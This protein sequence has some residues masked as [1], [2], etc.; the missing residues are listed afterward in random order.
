[1]QF[2]T[3]MILSDTSDLMRQHSWTISKK[4]ICG[5]EL[6]EKSYD[7]N[8]RTDRFHKQYFSNLIWET[9]FLGIP[10]QVYESSQ[11]SPNR[12]L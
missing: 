4:N 8:E 10:F 5:Q 7:Y 2:N 12:K 11:I 9:K 1:M 3:L 6:V